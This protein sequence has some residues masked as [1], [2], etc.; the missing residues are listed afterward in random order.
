MFLLKKLQI[1]QEFNTS[2]AK[3][4]IQ[5]SFKKIYEEH[6][7]VSGFIWPTAMYLFSI[8]NFV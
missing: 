4:D 5:L 6:L 1:S 7:F 3:H 2:G 8:N